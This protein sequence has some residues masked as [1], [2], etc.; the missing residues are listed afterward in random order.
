MLLPLMMVRLSPLTSARQLVSFNFTHLLVLILV[1][2]G[3]T[4]LMKRTNYHMDADGLGAM[5]VIIPLMI[6]QKKQC[7]EMTMDLTQARQFLTYVCIHLPLSSLHNK[8]K[9]HSV[10]GPCFIHR[11]K[12]QMA[13]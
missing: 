1:E 13:N 7:T 9:V 2:F 5:K 11:F 8:I 3:Q 10:N 6:L 12:L 4:S